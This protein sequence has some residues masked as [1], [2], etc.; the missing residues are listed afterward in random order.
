MKLYNDIKNDID[1]IVVYN[2]LAKY[3]ETHELI[4]GNDMQEKK[5]SKERLEKS[6][7]WF[8]EPQVE[9]SRNSAIK[10]LQEGNMTEFLQSVMNIDSSV[11]HHIMN[12]CARAENEGIRIDCVNKANNIKIRTIN[13]L[14]E[15]LVEKCGGE[16]NYLE[17]EKQ[18][19]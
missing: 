19:S 14:S 7:L 6:R 13:R 16:L 1:Q 18:N 5:Y 4:Q 17:E 11:E 10:K 3:I 2:K 15:A 8:L 12:N 9:I